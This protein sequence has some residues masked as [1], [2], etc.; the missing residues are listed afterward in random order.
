M[1]ADRIAAAYDGSAGD[2]DTGYGMGWWID[3]ESGRIS[4]PGAY[5]SVPWLV[6]KDGYGAYLVIESNSSDG[7]ALAGQL[8]D[9]VGDAVNAA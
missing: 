1:H 4:D 6:L 8:Y 5:G 2:T 7:N 3:R 9:I